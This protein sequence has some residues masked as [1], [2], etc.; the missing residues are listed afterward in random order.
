MDIDLSRRQKESLRVP[1]PGILV[2]P[3]AWFGF[4]DPFPIWAHIPICFSS[5]S[6]CIY[7]YIPLSSIFGI[8]YLGKTA[9]SSTFSVSTLTIFVISRF[10]EPVF[11][12]PGPLLAAIT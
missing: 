2:I 7:I 8:K 10:L 1:G 11:L 12:L 3:D 4:S 5:Y 9:A 6:N